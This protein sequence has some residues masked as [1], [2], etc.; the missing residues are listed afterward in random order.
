MK[1][2]LLVL[3]AICFTGCTS[4]NTHDKIRLNG[5]GTQQEIWKTGVLEQCAELSAKLTLQVIEEEQVKGKY[6]LKDQ[7]FMINRYFMEKCIVSGKIV[8]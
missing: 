1:T 6:L 8:I 4:I 5:P 7:S 2:L 3:A